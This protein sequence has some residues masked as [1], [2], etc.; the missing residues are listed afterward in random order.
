MKKQKTQ[1]LKQ[2]LVLYF[3]ENFP[4]DVIEVLKS[5]SYWRKKCK[6]YT[7]FDEGNTNKDDDFHFEYCRNKGMTLVTLD[8]H[9]MDDMQ[10]PFSKIPGIIRIVARKN[11]SETILA[12]LWNLLEFVSFFPLPKQFIGDS[13][14]EVSS[15]GCMIRAR[16]A[17]TRE[18][19]TMKVRA[20]DPSNKVRKK[21]VKGDI[22]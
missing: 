17:L 7:A 22:L 2:K 3:N 9:F 15:K 20:G 18:I 8:K 19:K 4:H 13:K 6:I 11:D 5:N 1:Y 14:F 10:Y 16:D 12:N 21:F